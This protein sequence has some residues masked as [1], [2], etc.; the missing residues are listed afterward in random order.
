MSSLRPQ[1]RKSLCRFTFADGRQCRIPRSPGH[2]RLC[3]DHARKDSQARAADKLARE[4]SYFFSGPYLS[5]CDLS[6][7]LGRLMADVARGDIKPRSARTLAYLAQT[8]VQTIHLAQDEYINAFETDGWRRAVRNSV[9]GNHSYLFPPDPQPAQ[10]ESPQPHPA[11]VA[12]PLRGEA[13][14]S[15][16]PPQT[17]Q[18][19]P[20]P[21]TPLPPTSAE[22]AEHVLAARN[23]SRPSRETGE[24]RTPHVVAGLETGDSPASNHVSSSATTPASPGLSSIHAPARRSQPTPSST[25]PPARPTTPPIQ[26]S[27]GAQHSPQ[28]PSEPQP[29]LAAAPSAAPQGTRPPAGPQTGPS[30]LPVLAPLP[31]RKPGAPACSR[32]S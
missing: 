26:S 18:P 27:T 11:A 21:R 10:P 3:S 13:L 12:D 4:L 22:F 31:P 14:P 28:P 1:D 17:Q 9:R 24:G 25:L 16:P 32:S 7:A 29:L 23:L 15:A 2:S 20:P 5:A 19:L 8:L 30:G 6:A